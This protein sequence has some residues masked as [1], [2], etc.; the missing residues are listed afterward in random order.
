VANAVKQQAAKNV[1]QAS[2]DMARKLNIASVATGVETHE[3]WVLMRQLC[4]Q[5]AQGN[6]IAKPMPAKAFLEWSGARQRR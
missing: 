6:F 1:V 3:D 4:C 5:G 2:L